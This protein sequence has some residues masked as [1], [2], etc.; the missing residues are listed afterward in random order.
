[1]TRSRVCTRLPFA[2]F[3]LEAALL[4]TG[5][6]PASDE[7]AYRAEIHAAREERLAELRDDP[8]S[9]LALVHREYLGDRTEITFGSSP[10]ADI[11]LHGEKIAPVHAKFD[12]NYSPPRVHEVHPDWKETT[13][14]QPEFFSMTELTTNTF[15]VGRYLVSYRPDA[16]VRGDALEIFD[17]EEPAL[18]EFEGLEFYPVDPASRVTAEVVPH[19]DPQETTLIDSQGNDRRYWIY[20]DLRFRLQE[21]DL[22]LEIYSTTTD[23]A[24]IEEGRFQLMFTDETSGAGTYPAGR[25]LYVEGKRA[26]MITVDFNLS[27]NPPCNFSPVYTCP[28]PRSQN[29]L[30]VA[31]RAGEKKYRGKTATPLSN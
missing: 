3:L 16:P 7:E 25:Y 30:P 6:A 26:G 27:F 8:T 28:F 22:T 23:P 31:L 19:E 2:L 21:Q 17:T 29:R 14:G 15:G 1:M 12:T 13:S 24:K 20:G 4:G 11:R 5:C 18:K 9:R 10:E